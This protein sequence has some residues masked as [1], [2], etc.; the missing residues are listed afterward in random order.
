MCAK[1][2]ALNR[3]VET[4]TCRQNRR[5]TRHAQMRYGIVGRRDRQLIRSLIRRRR[6]RRGTRRDALRRKSLLLPQ[7][8]RK[9]TTMINANVKRWPVIFLLRRRRIAS[10][11]LGSPIGP[12]RGIAFPRLIGLARRIRAALAR[13][14]K[15]RGSLAGRTPPRPNVAHAGRQAPQPRRHGFRL[16]GVQGSLGHPSSRHANATAAKRRQSLHKTGKDRPHAHHG[17]SHSTQGLRN[18]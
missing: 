5:Q 4:T 1:V 18:C 12:G 14:I 6:L 17:A 16:S 13:G 7:K 8:L 9:K 3:K 10:I 15:L 11:S 2:D